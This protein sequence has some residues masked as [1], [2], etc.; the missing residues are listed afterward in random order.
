MAQSFLGTT[1]ARRAIVVD[2]YLRFLARY[3]SP[4]ESA[5]WV[6]T[7]GSSAAGEQQLIAT[8]ASGAEYLNGS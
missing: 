4:D 5:P 3:P 6:T 8:L 1:E 7:L 2:Q